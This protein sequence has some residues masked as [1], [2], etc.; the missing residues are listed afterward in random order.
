MPAHSHRFIE[1]FEGFVG[2][3]LN[4]ESDKDTVI[5]YLQKFSDD[6]LM[7]LLRDRLSD[8]DRQSIF[9]L[10]STILREH[11]SEPEYHRYFLRDD[12]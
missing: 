7:A 12:H 9:D 5:Y 8:H 6:R 4:R 10:I 11:L 2:F 3:G 1:E